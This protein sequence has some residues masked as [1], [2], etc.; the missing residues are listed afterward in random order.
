M[1]GAQQVQ[2]Q[3]DRMQELRDR[4]K[5]FINRKEW[6]LASKYLE[7]VLSR[8]QDAEDQWMPD[9]GALLIRSQVRLHLANYKNALED[10]RLA[11]LCLDRLDIR[12]SR[13]LKLMAEAQFHLGNYEHSLLYF[14]RSERVLKK[15]TEEGKI[16]IQR[17]LEAINSLLDETFQKDLQG[18]LPKIRVTNSEETSS[19]SDGSEKKFLVSKSYRRTN[20]SV[21][22]G[23]CSKLSNSSFSISQNR[24][25]RVCG[26][27]YSLLPSQPFTTD[28]QCFQKLLNTLDKNKGRRGQ[29][30]KL[31]RYTVNA[32]QYIQNTCTK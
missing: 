16:G 11:N 23:P 24:P 22:T 3:L 25:I 1:L 19:F 30:R 4:A 17:C 10:A 14:Y 18:E 26:R 15:G 7:I 6:N 32:I 12:Q 5:F 29:E 21:G 28:I 27:F 31:R 20:R 8:P 2:Q 9:P 13:A